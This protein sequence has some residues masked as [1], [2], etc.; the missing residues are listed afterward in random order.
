MTAFKNIPP[1]QDFVKGQDSDMLRMRLAFAAELEKMH[2]QTLARH[3]AMKT[4]EDERKAHERWEQA[5]TAATKRRK[6]AEPLMSCPCCA[7]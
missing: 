7:A 1:W 2:A 6:K 4:T 3:S 5:Q